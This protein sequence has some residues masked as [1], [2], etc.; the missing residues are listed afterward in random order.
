M[1]LAV[2]VPA[3]SVGRHLFRGAEHR[4]ELGLLGERRSAERDGKQRRGGG[5]L[6]EPHETKLLKALMGSLAERPDQSFRSRCIAAFRAA[7]A[8]RPPPDG[9]LLTALACI[10]G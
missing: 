5:C 10:I 2:P 3:E 4:H 9:E 6:D 1:T 7:R 8:R